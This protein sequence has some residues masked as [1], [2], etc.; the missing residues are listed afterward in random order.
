MGRNWSQLGAFH[1]K[2][3]PVDMYFENLDPVLL[4]LIFFVLFKIL[5]KLRDSFKILIFHNLNMQMALWA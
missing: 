5:L 2:G 4:L 3:N 1:Q